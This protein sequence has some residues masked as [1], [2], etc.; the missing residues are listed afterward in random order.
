MLKS[1]SKNLCHPFLRLNYLSPTMSNGLAKP[2]GET[3]IFLDASNISRQKIN[4][5]VKKM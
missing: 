1:F 2:F 5:I 3:T 4:V